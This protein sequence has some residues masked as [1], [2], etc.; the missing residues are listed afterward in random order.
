MIVS[1]TGMSLD[2][3]KKQVEFTPEDKKQ[4]VK[5]KCEEKY[6][7][8]V[9]SL[10]DWIVGYM[11]AFNG[12]GDVAE[13]LA[14]VP[15]NATECTKNAPSEFAN[16][17]WLEKGKLIKNVAVSVS[18]IKDNCEKITEEMKTVKNEMQDMNDA[19]G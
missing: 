6:N 15:E 2:D 14:N 18:K 9:D 1:E 7:D 13:K 16:L 3:L 8:L 10:N 12:L 17:E 5:I 19:F 4:P 11:D